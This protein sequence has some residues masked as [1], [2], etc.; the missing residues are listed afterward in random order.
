MG[1]K[2]I[3]IRE[4]AMTGIA[5]YWKFMSP[6][7]MLPNL[8]SANKIQDVTNEGHDSR[9]ARDTGTT[10]LS[11]CIVDQPGPLQLRF[12]QLDGSLLKYGQA[13]SSSEIRSSDGGGGS[14]GSSDPSLLRLFSALPLLFSSSH[15]FVSS[16]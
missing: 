11:L 12:V 10:Y 6:V 13:R 7:N 14:S 8:K 1:L 2:S 16:N 15:V 3:F 9:G 4:Y 5:E